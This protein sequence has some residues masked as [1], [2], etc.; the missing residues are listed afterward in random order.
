VRSLTVQFP[1]AK[2]IPGGE[3]DFHMHTTTS[4][5][6]HTGSQLV[7]LL[8]MSGVGV[9][10][11]T[12]HD[13]TAT[14]RDPVLSRYLDALGDDAPRIVP[15]VEITCALHAPLVDGGEQEVHIIGLGVNA[16]D[17][18]LR[19]ALINQRLG[20]YAR[21][22]DS[23]ARLR[24]DGYDISLGDVTREARE[25]MPNRG[26]I[27]R[28]I[29]HAGYADSWGAGLK[30]VDAHIGDYRAMPRR[31]TMDAEDAIRLIHEAGGVAILAH[32]HRV[33]INHD[34]EILRGLFADLRSKGL[35][36]AEA[37]RYD[38]AKE[39]S[40]EYRALIEEAGLLPS[41]GSDFHHFNQ[42]G[43]GRYPGDADAPAELW[44]PM[45]ALI[46]ERG[47]L[48]DVR[49]LRVKAHAQANASE[50]LLLRGA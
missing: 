46:S 32:P 5:G 1:I 20:I 15:G 45:A 35:D 39:R 4:D 48:L 18:G 31:F 19:K 25:C 33:V 41:G 38:L 44:A 40:P 34:P 8:R 14:V 42:R 37:Y 3:V 10:A 47:G 29:H 6:L 17:H 27:A 49:D 23:V 12:D 7:D 36:A 26:H 16:N 50:Q 21:M 28:A 2:A 9:A 22:K 13:D 11:I 43:S 30:I 24:A